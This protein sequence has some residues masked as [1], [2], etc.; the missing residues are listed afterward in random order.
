MTD[1]KNPPAEALPSQTSGEE[2]GVVN[3]ALALLSAL[4]V[5][6]YPHEDAWESDHVWRTKVEPAKE[7]L[8]A[9]LIALEEAALAD[10][11]ARRG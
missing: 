7:R 10:G 3:A 6:E 4:R 5:H 1:R 11:G 9:A 2:E 8:H